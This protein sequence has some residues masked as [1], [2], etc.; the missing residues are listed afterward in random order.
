MDTICVFHCSHHVMNTVLQ[1]G[2]V[3]CGQWWI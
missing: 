1:N 2:D 3:G